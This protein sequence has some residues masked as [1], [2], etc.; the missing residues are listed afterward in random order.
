MPH[1]VFIGALSPIA[2]LLLVR[3]EG[4]ERFTW[5]KLA[6]LLICLLGVLLLAVD[7]TGGA[8]ANWRGDLMAFAGMWCFAFYTVRSK[9]LAGTYDSVSLNTYAFVIA[10][11]FCFPVLLLVGSAVPW[12]RI[13]WIGWSALLYSATFGSAGP[14]LAY[15]YSLRTLTASQA[16]AFQYVQP[17][18]STCFGVWFLAETF[19]SRF[20]AGAAL[21]LAG[22]FLAE[23]R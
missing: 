22:M 18:L 23:R 14:Y 1:A 2:V 10:A 13:S 16:A 20:E 19:G 9:D 8:G 21:I 3:V 11:L 15:Y 5:L 12:P 17:V 7:K 4:Q 6:G